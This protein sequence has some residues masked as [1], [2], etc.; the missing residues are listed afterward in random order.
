MF[1]SIFVVGGA[2]GQHVVQVV[3]VVPACQAFGRWRPVDA[4]Q[5]L[6]QD[7]GVSPG[8]QL[9]QD[10]PFS[11]G[12]GGFRFGTRGVRDPEWQIVVLD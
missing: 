4:V 11:L 7:G 3:R 6:L 5:V 8:A 2:L 1:L 10:G 9:T 12:E